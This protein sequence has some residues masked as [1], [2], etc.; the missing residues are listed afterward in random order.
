VTL[1][2]PEP[3]ERSTSTVTFTVTEVRPTRTVSV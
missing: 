1:T 3:F 2:R